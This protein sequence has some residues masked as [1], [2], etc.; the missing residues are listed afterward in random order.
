MSEKKKDAKGDEG[1]FDE[2]EH[3]P[4]FNKK[5][6][7]MSDKFFKE[8]DPDFHAMMKQVQGAARKDD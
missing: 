1:G 5:E 4:E 7:E 2:H 6:R 8:N 3:T